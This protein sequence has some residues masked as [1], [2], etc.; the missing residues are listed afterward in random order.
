MDKRGSGIL[1]HIASLP[2]PYGIGDLGPG[3][4]RFADFLAQIKQRFW[5]VLPLNPTDPAFGN[6]PYSSNSAFAGN[7]L[8]ISPE[9]LLAE[10]LID[11]E[12][13]GSVPSFP[14]ESVDYPSVI[15]YKEELFNLTYEHMRRNHKDPPAYEQFCSENAYWLESFSLFM[16]IKRHSQGKVWSEWERELRDRNPEHLRIIKEQFHDELE[17][18]K[19]LQYLFWKQWRSL[20]R[21]CNEK[22]IQLI[23]DMPIYVNYD[24]AGVWAHPETFKL[25]QDRRP[26]F[27]A[28]VPPD[29]FSR[30]GQFWGNPVYRWDV[31]RE[32]GYRWWIRRVAHNLALFD[33]VRV[34]HF[35]GFVAF[36][37]IPA[38]EQTAANGHW[39]QA[40]AEDFFTVLTRSLSNLSIIAEDLGTITPDVKEIM[41]RFGFP[42]MRVLLFAFGEDLPTHPNQPHNYVSNCVAYTGTHDN[43]TVKGWFEGEARL[44]E[45]QRL[46]R[47]LGREVSAGNVHTELIRLA[48]MSIGNT[49]IFPMQDVLGLGEEARMNRP[50]RHEG[51]WEW[52]LL[53]EQVTPSLGSSLLEM[54]ETYGRA[55]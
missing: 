38:A 1:L 28:G 40:P 3:A 36:W 48:M 5:Q 4:Y 35:R 52:R 16:V 25:D 30:T 54:T 2:S 21:Y 37:E 39:V 55:M 45:K 12:D 22:G 13:V 41:K 23:G 32:T 19:F 18:E 10:G 46:F 7:T 53:P 11:R 6:S 34:D 8:L 15:R 49:V 33:L 44:S 47:Y 27:V 50:A 17:K 20:K 14:Q 42:G 9:L 29:Y 43:N 31:L 24:S 51:N 26:A